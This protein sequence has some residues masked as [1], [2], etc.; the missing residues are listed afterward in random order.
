MSRCTRRSTATAARSRTSPAPSRGADRADWV[1]AIAVARRLRALPWLAHGLRLVP[2]GARLADE[3]EL[4]PAQPLDVAL[5]SDGAHAQAQLLARVAAARGAG[6]LHVL[7]RALFPSP[8]Y[9]RAAH[10]DAARGR[11]AL[12]AAYVRRALS[13]GRALR[14]LL[15][16]AV[17][18]VIYEAYGLRI[19]SELPLPELNAGSG[20]PDV[21]LVR[22]DVEDELCSDELAVRVDGE[23]LRLLW[24]GVARVAVRGGRSVVVDANGADDGQ[25][26]RLLLGPA[27]A[28]L[29]VQRGVTVLHASAVSIGGRAVAFAGD[30]GAGKS[31]TAAALHLRGHPAVAD[32]VLAATSLE[33]GP[34][35]LPGFPHLKIDVDAA[36]GLGAG[37]LQPMHDG[38]RKGMLPTGAHFAADPLP[39]ACIY[40]LAEGDEPAVEPLRPHE[41]VIELVRHSW[42]VRTFA[43][44]E[45]TQLE[46]CTTLARGVPVRRLRRPRSLE[47]LSGLAALVEADVR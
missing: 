10:P 5:R 46:R 47:A 37:A 35:A 12:A 38:F 33:D 30:S 13:A 25:L 22:G 2:E 16:A 18:A 3:L 32:D 8:A 21:H 40:V 34:L 41:S 24:R 15:R 45:A 17:G 7:W 28:A 4:P 36:A 9:M 27:L 6:R 31:T 43:L 44:P 42:G 39:L 20:E 11:R 1:N 26:R 23:D 14:P 29:L 19:A